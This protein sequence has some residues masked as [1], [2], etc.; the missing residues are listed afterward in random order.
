MYETQGKFPEALGQYEKALKASPNDLASLISIARLH[1]RQGNF[2]K[3]IET[4]NRAAKAHPKSGLV[5]NDLG[6]C[7]ARQRNSGSAIEHLTQ[8]CE[9]SPK[10]PKYRN[11]LATVLV[12]GGRPDE[13]FRQLCILSSEGTAHYNVAYMWPMIG[14]CQSVK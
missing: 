8:A 6:L 5:Q 13:A 12:E 3:A 4:Y 9:F 11:N 14:F 7:Y 10:N 2:P 1:D